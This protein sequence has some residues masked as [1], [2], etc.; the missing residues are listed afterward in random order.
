MKNNQDLL[1][2][3]FIGWKQRGFD[4]MALNQKKLRIAEKLQHYKHE[5]EKLESKRLDRIFEICANTKRTQNTLHIILQTTSKEEALKKIT[6]GKINRREI[7]PDVVEYL[8]KNI[9]DQLDDDYKYVDANSECLQYKE[10]IT[11]ME[12][13]WNQRLNKLEEL[14]SVQND[15]NNLINLTGQDELKHLVAEIIC[16]FCRGYIQRFD[17]LF[18][19]CFYGDPGL[20]KTEFAKRIAAIFGKLG[21]YFFS[22]APVLTRPDFVGGYVGQSALK[23]KQ[24]LAKYTESVIIIDEAY[25]LSHGP[26]DEFGN[27]ALTTLNEH[28]TSHKDSICCIIIGYKVQMEQKFFKSNPGLARRFQYQI[29]FQPYDKDQLY[30]IFSN[31][32]ALI[33][34]DIQ[35]TPDVRNELSIGNKNAADMVTLAVRAVQYASLKKALIIDKEIFNLAQTF[36]NSNS[37][38]YDNY[39]SEMELQQDEIIVQPQTQKRRRMEVDY[40]QF[41]D[42]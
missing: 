11:K 1:T 28:L 21:I 38:L 8:C 25:A 24:V 3:L 4:Q 10:I 14:S 18:N 16:D 7:T 32:C 42:F 29:I 26:N 34:E 2:K 22:E 36:K 20:G 41:Y 40:S 37:K 12:E 31:Q 39:I 33:N 30:N 9:A 35:I 13:W 17:N 6:S 19:F 23:T 5:V 27:E 15:I